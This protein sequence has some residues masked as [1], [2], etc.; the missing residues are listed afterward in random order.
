[1]EKNITLEERYPNICEILVQNGTNCKKVGLFHSS[2][3]Q[4]SEAFPYLARSLG[5]P[6]TG[7]IGCACL[8]CGEGEPGTW[9]LIK[10]GTTF[11]YLY[12]F[13]K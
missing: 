9:S 1:M 7:R 11:I 12:I 8:Y 4:Q 2:P 5:A 6:T 13:L 3:F 10:K